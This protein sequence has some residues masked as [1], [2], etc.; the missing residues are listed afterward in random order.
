MISLLQHLGPEV[1]L[2]LLLLALL[3][4]RARVNCKVSLFIKAPPDVLWAMLNPQDGKTDDW[5]RTVVVTKLI[6]PASETYEMTYTTATANGASRVFRGQFR[7][8]ARQDGHLVVLQRAGLEGKSEHNELLEISHVLTP[9]PGGSRLTT[10]YIWGARQLLAQLLARADLW[11]GAYRLKG[12]AENGVP[13]NR[14]YFLISG[15][16]ALF[17]GLLSI[18]AFGFS[19]GYGVALLLVLALLVHEFGHLLAFRLVG[20]PWGR[21]VFLPFLGAIAVPRLPFESQGQT[22]FSALMGPAFSSLFALA[23]LI[24][25]LL[26]WHSAKAFVTLGVIIAGLNIF[27]M[28]P[29]EPLDGGIALRSVLS[30]L[31]GRFAP[32]GLMLI[33]LLIAGV[34]YALSQF[35]LVL[36]GGMA[37]LANLKPRKIDTGLDPLTSLQVCIAFFSYVTIAVTHYALFYRFLRQMGL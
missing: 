3:G 17:T 33:G 8:S 25:G 13:N 32:L 27:N 31:I 26:G 37:I 2:T 28:L 29:A 1:P 19:L 12:L 9:E 14:P 18:G 7:V 34:G 11:G 10:R 22:V 36:F 35:V 4:F 24:P 20:Q 5:G 16:V 30:R 15:G 23:C 21:L 6:A